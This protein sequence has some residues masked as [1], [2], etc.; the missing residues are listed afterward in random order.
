MVGMIDYKR[1]AMAFRQ[2]DKQ[3]EIEGARKAFK[4]AKK[5]E[6]EAK[7]KEREDQMKQVMENVQKMKDLP[8]GEK[9]SAKE[10]KKRFQELTD[11]TQEERD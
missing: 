7:K 2:A 11:Y 5:L 8:A 4:Q 1:L 9:V 3:R 6:K 10:G